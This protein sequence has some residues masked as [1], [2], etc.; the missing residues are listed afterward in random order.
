MVL[1][2]IHVN[3]SLPT[4]DLKASSMKLSAIVLYGN[5]LKPFPILVQE[6]VQRDP[7]TIKGSESGNPASPFEHFST[8]HNIPKLVDL[9]VA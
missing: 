5:G 9:R 6:N 2:K 8:S 3:E 1:S 4:P 7:R